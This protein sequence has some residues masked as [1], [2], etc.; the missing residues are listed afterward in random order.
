M[1]LGPRYL[2]PWIPVL[3]FLALAAEPRLFDDV[4]T[5]LA[6]APRALGM[7]GIILILLSFQN[8]E[9]AYSGALTYWLLQPDSV[10]PT[11]P[12]YGSAAYFGCMRH[13]AWSVHKSVLL[14]AFDPRLDPRAFAFACIVSIGMAHFVFRFRAKAKACA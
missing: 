13:W 1:V 3:A 8:A 14:K 4:F 9:E 2:I 10:C 12:E 7:V 6:R 11:D 5:R